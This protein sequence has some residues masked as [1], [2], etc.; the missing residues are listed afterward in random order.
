V[1]NIYIWLFVTGSLSALGAVIALA[2]PLTILSAFIAA[3][4]TTLNPFI[5]AGWVAGLVEAWI[6]KP[7][8]SDFEALPEAALSIKSFWTNHVTKILLVVVFSNI[9]SALGV[10]V[11]GIWIVKRT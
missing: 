3:P 2:H 5:A 8:V 4:F 7:T 1:Q 11:A 9:G 10:Y 6:R